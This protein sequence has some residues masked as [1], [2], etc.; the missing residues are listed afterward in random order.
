MDIVEV[1]HLS[2]VMISSVSLTQTCYLTCFFYFASLAKT[3]Y[4]TACPK[5]S[6]HSQIP[7]HSKMILNKAR[8]WY[9][10]ILM[11]HLYLLYCIYH[12]K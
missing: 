8:L 7:E 6:A 10:V 5:I 3:R 4:A 2:A 12:W 9:V 11:G 1:D